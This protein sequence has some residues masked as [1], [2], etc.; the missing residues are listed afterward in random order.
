MIA[1][2]LLIK[3]V[4]SFCEITAVVNLLAIFLK[5]A[6]PNTFDPVK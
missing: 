6:W 2:S 1:S 3:A 4:A 5:F